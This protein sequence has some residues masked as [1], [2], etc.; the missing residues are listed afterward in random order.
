MNKQMPS[1]LL[2]SGK[3]IDKFILSRDLKGREVTPRVVESPTKLVEN[4]V[5]CV[6]GSDLSHEVESEKPKEQEG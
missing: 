6:G 1:L 5:P 2:R 3:E 4:G